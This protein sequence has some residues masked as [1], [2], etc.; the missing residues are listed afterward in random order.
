MSARFFSWKAVDKQGLVHTGL[1]SGTDQAQIRMQL[2]RSGYYPVQIRRHLGRNLG[3]VLRDLSR[4]RFVAARSAVNW[5]DLARRLALLLQ[6]G[7]PLL[8]ALKMVA[9][10]YADNQIQSSLCRM[11]EERVAAGDDLSEALRQ[12]EPA[13]SPFVLGM[14]KSGEQTGTLAK[15]LADL[16]DQ[17]DRRQDFERKLRSALS[18]PAL[19]LTGVVVLVIVLALWVLPL[20]ENLYTNLGSELPT[21]TG[22]IFDA[23]HLL[24]WLGL[25]LGLITIGGLLALGR[26]YPRT[27]RWELR[28]LSGSLPVIGPLQ[29][30]R[31]LAEFVDVLARLLN[32]GI[33]LLE[34]LHTTRGMLQ[35]VRLIRLTDSLL[36][37]V[38]QGQRLGPILQ[39]SSVFPSVACEM[40][41]VAEETGKLDQ[42]FGYVALVLHADIERELERWVKVLEPALLVILAGIIGL[43]AVGV[44][45]PIFEVGTYVQ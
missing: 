41:G 34:A 13:P 37:G 19:L 5:S 35:D 1:I 10:A 11:I 6:A 15:V 22:V 7:I 16:A 17:L 24:P 21:L 44:L 31:Q 4:A 30:Q 32:A 20:Y 12:A 25:G 45:L 33:P 9:G 2:R 39:Q 42:M 36:H 18:Y 28:R 40:I 43:V 26:R 8:D 23:G 3:L 14:V 38:R 29:Q 27:W